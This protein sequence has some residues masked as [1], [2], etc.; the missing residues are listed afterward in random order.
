MGLVFYFVLIGAFEAERVR[1]RIRAGEAP[2]RAIL[3]RAGPLLPLLVGPVGLYAGSNLAGAD[4]SAQWLGVREKLAQLLIPVVNY[5]LP[6]DVVTACLTAG[7]VAACVAMRRVRIPMRSGLAIAALG[8]LYVAAPFKLKGTAA[9]D[10]RFA[11]MLGFMLFG[12]VLPVLRPR[13]ARLAAVAFAALFAVRMAVLAS[14]WHGHARD[15]AELRGVIAGVPAG[16]RVYL[17][18][19]T[20]ADAPGYWQRGPRARRL[21]DGTQTDYHMAALLVIERH[22]F[23][24]FLFAQAAQQPIEVAPR[25]H[26]LAMQTLLLSD[27]AFVATCRAAPEDLRALDAALCGYDDVLLLHAGAVAHLRRCGAGRLVLRAKSD[28]AALFAVKADGADCPGA[29]SGLAQD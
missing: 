13:I 16:S 25:Y 22:A 6:L 20:P 28:L 10:S 27:R 21:S 7:F 19:V 26:A 1:H 11:I 8:A 23:W 2:W 4:W 5:D 3:R 12:A 15:L 29:V 14:A 24:P 9:L 17:A 18:T